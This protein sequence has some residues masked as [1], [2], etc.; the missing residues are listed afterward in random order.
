[1]KTKQH[2]STLKNV[3]RHELA[4]L[5][6]FVCGSILLT[7]CQTP[8]ISI[9]QVRLSVV[10]PQESSTS[11]NDRQKIDEAVMQAAFQDTDFETAPEMPANNSASRLAPGKRNE[12]GQGNSPKRAPDVITMSDQLQMRSQSNMQPHETVHGNQRLNHPPGESF[13]QHSEPIYTQGDPSTHQ[14]Y[15]DYFQSIRGQS[16]HPLRSS[17]R[18]QRLPP[19]QQ[20][21]TERALEL[22]SEINRLQNEMVQQQD[23]LKFWNQEYQSLRGELALTIQSLKRA[24]EMLSDIQMRYKKSQQENAMLR[25]SLSELGQSISQSDRKTEAI[26]SKLRN[27]IHGQ[28][29]DDPRA[30]LRAPA[31]MPGRPPIR[32]NV[33]QPETLPRLKVK[34]PR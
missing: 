10:S 34:Q 4:V 9:P 32:T 25:K 20:T 33:Q 1:M 2:I 11:K 21:A 12:I 6:G 30:R 16:T 15:K 8:A 31:Q 14:S 29:S 22:Q 7:G 26:L 27:A 13:Y 17:I 5:I 3:K 18:G 24:N 28:L 23:Q 19:H